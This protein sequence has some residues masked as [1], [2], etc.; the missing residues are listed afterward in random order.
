MEEDNKEK[1]L[2]TKMSLIIPTVF[3][4]ER[5][6]V[7]SY[8]D[9]FS[10]LLKDRIVF[11]QGEVTSSMASVIIAELLFLEKESEKQPIQMFIMSPG[12]SV[13]AGLA[14]YD[15]MQYIKCPVV[16]IGLGEV[17]SIAAVLLSAGAKGMRY[18]LPNTDIMIHQPW[19][20][21]IQKVNVTQLKI[22]TEFLE[23]TKDKLIRILA[24]HTGKSLKQVEKDVELDNWLTAKQAKEYG[25]ID[26]IIK[27]NNI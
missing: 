21:S 6:G 18:A 7:R 16:T 22:T 23:R 25:L 14:I 26:K 10:R 20:S 17:A 3:E 8:Y 4:E 9:I 24:K 15:T 1:E 2:K 12:G 5:T 13:G 11:V 27:F 19:I